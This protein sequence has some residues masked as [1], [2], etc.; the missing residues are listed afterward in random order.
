MGEEIL[1]LDLMAG[2][3]DVSLF[4]DG[5]DW[6][7]RGKQRRK[8]AGKTGKNFPKLGRFGKN[9]E[10]CQDLEKGLYRCRAELAGFPNPKLCQS[11]RKMHHDG[12][13]FG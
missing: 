7:R 1:S 11:R 4:W 8:T 13:K 9:A 10:L 6:L 12:E 2:F 5:M 3:V